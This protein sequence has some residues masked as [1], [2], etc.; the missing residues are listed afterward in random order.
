MAPRW[1]VIQVQDGT[2]PDS[3]GRFVQGKTVTYQLETGHT[4]TVF[5]PA[6]NANAD[7]VKLAVAADAA[8]L[9][10]IANLTSD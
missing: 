5:V 6:P 3:T 8:N 2:G 9:D 7:A 10:A 1:R 4:G